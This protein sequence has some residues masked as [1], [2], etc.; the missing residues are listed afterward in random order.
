MNGIAVD[1]VLQKLFYTDYAFVGE[2]SDSYEIM[3]A[4]IRSMSYNGT[5][6]VDILTE[7]DTLLN[8]KA[9]IVDTNLRYIIYS[10]TVYKNNILKLITLVDINNMYPVF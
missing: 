8:P 2:P 10:I 4:A 9:I 5:N 1:P 7:N 6:T 3:Y